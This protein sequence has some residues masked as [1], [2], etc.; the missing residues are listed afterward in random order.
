MKRRGIRQMQIVNDTPIQAMIVDPDRGDD[1][2]RL[3][4]E[5]QGAD[6]GFA[7]VLSAG[8]SEARLEQIGKVRHCIAQAIRG[9]RAVRSRGG[10]PVLPT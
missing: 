1:V 3:L 4:N 10:M 7:R 5:L 8:A 2:N 9:I 6:E